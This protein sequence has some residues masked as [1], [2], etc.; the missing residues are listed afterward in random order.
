MVGWI[1]IN[2]QFNGGEPQRLNLNDND[3]A[4]PTT[5]T[6]QCNFNFLIMYVVPIRASSPQHIEYNYT[7]RASSP[8]LKEQKL[9]EHQ[10]LNV[11]SKSSHGIKPSTSNEYA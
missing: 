11:K 9:T 10:T 3:N 8:Q 1:D 4:T 7:H 6:R 5:S 2:A